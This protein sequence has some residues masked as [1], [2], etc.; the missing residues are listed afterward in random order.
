MTN[1]TQDLRQAVEDIKTAILQGQYEASKGVNRIQLAVYFGIGK[2]V[3]QHT[4]KGVWGTGALETI[5][6]QLRRELPGLTLIGV[7]S[8]CVKKMICQ[9][10]GY[11]KIYLYLRH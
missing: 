2:Y 3:S 6:N 8:L 1:L 11:K 10:F 7:V 5:S 9:I 4:R